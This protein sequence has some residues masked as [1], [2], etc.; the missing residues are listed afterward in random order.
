MVIHHIL[1]VYLPHL[2]Y[3]GDDESTIRDKAA[4]YAGSVL[5]R[6]QQS[7]YSRALPSA[8][9][10][11]GSNVLLCSE[12]LDR[13]I[14]ELEK[15]LGFQKSEVMYCLNRIEESTSK[16]FGNVIRGLYSD[17]FEA[18]YEFPMEHIRCV[19]QFLAGEYQISS[20]FY[21][22]WEKTARLL[23]KDIDEIKKLPGDWALVQFVLEL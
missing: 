2:I 10:D 6:F 18:G 7:V 14:R 1:L 19:S 5:R 16:D 23:P 4:S 12:D 11:G 9:N 13:A 3:A 20:R 22:T 17:S 21:N 15:I 8:F